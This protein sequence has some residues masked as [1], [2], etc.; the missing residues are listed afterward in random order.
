MII[1][2]DYQKYRKLFSAT[3]HRKSTADLENNKGRRNSG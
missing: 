2:I 1:V 3:D